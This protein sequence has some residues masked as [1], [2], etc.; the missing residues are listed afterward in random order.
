[1]NNRFQHVLIII[2]VVV[3][4][5]L[6]NIYASVNQGYKNS[7]FNVV[8]VSK[9]IFNDTTNVNSTE[10]KVALLGVY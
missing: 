8:G 6:S 5:Y 9:V 10:N 2:F 7:S 1:M 3:I 4:L